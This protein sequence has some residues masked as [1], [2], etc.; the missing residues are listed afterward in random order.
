MEGAEESIIGSQP[1]SFVTLSEAEGNALLER[2][3][4]LPLADAKE[5][6]KTFGDLDWGRH[7]VVIAWLRHFG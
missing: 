7:D 3:S 5:Q 1:G 4:A 2:L 6:L